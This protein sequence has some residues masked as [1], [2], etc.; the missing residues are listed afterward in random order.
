VDSCPKFSTNSNAS[1]AN[2]IV[3]A[4]GRDRSRS[5]VGKGPG[6]AGSRARPLSRCSC[7]G[8]AGCASSIA[9]SRRTAQRCARWFPHVPEPFDAKQE[10]RRLNGALDVLSK[11]FLGRETLTPRERVALAQIVRGASSKE[12]ADAR[13]QPANRRSPSRQSAEKARRQ[14][15]GRSRA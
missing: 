2:N 12:A 9:R 11:P 13:H 10:I 4:S 14:E 1:R 7:R 3:V 6:R 15:H 5:S 8:R